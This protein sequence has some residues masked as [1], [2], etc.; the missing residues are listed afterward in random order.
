[1]LMI[2]EHLVMHSKSI[3]VWTFN[4]AGFCKRQHIFYVLFVFSW[5]C[6]LW[7]ILCAINKQKYKQS[8]YKHININFIS[9]ISSLCPYKCPFKFFVIRYAYYKAYEI[10]GWQVGKILGFLWLNWRLSRLWCRYS[11]NFSIRFWRQYVSLFTSI[12]AI[13]PYCWLLTEKSSH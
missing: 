8:R 2:I 13:V 6:L 4:C 5:Q 9:H 11:G 7:E 10:S 3:L 12:T 1:M